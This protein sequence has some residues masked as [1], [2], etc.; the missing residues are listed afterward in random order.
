[1]ESEFEWELDME[2]IY[3]DEV[4]FQVGPYDTVTIRFLPTHLEIK[5]IECDHEISRND[6]TVEG[7]CQEICQSVEKGIKTATSA[8]NYINAQHLFT[9]YCTS[10]SCSEDPHPAKLMKLKGKVR[11]LK[12]DKLNKRFT[13]PSGYEKWQLDSLSQRTASSLYSIKK[14]CHPSFFE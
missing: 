11:N 4:C 2:K 5:L 1:M 7:I 8:I 9:F 14:M 3:R 6:C 13:L 12:C 10:E